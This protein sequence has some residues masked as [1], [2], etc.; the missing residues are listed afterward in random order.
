[1]NIV[2]STRANLNVHK[3]MP[4]IN[5]RLFNP[6]LSDYLTGKTIRIRLEKDNIMPVI[7]FVLAFNNANTG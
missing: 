4:S 6:N 1:M 2:S 7:S 5:L 3:V